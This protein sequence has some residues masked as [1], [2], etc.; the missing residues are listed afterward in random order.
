MIGYL[1]N[2]DRETD[3]PFVLFVDD[4]ASE[5]GEEPRTVE[6]RFA[7]LVEMAATVTEVQEQ[8]GK[9]TLMFGEPRHFEMAREGH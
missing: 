7:T 9:F 6:V 1:F 5:D 2:D 3:R 4:L 8:L